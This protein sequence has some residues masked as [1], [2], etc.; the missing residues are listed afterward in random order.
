M[1]N[2][3]VDRVGTEFGEQ[4]ISSRIT[5]VGETRP[6]I[7]ISRRQEAQIFKILRMYN[8]SKSIGAR[9]QLLDGISNTTYSLLQRYNTFT[10]FAASENFAASVLGRAAWIVGGRALGRL[11]SRLVPQ[12]GGP[13]GRF[14][15]V[16]AGHFSRNI[17]SNAMKYFVSVEM[18]I[19]NIPQ[20]QKDITRDLMRANQLGPT[21]Q[22]LTH[23]QAIKTAPDY[24]VGGFGTTGDMGSRIDNIKVF[25]LDRNSQYVQKLVDAGFTGHEINALVNMSQ[26]E[27]SMLGETDID[28]VINAFGKNRTSMLKAAN[29]PYNLRNNL[30]VDYARLYEFGQRE[31]PNGIAEAIK[32]TTGGD[33]VIDEQ[34]L[35]S[36]GFNTGGLYTTHDLQADPA[37][38]ADL[39][40]N[41]FSG[42]QRGKN[43]AKLYKRDDKNNKIESDLQRLG[44]RTKV[45]NGKIVLAPRDQ[46]MND[47]DEFV[48]E[49]D[50][51]VQSVLKDGLDIDFLNHRQVS[52]Q[53]TH[54]LANYNKF[55]NAIPSKRL[56]QSDIESLPPLIG[57]KANQ[58]TAFLGFAVS[59]GANIRDA[60]QIEYGGPATDS[61]GKLKRRSDRFIYPRS[62]FMAKSAEYAANAL[63]IK[64]KIGYSQAKGGVMKHM[65]TNKEKQDVKE[66][67]QNSNKANTEYKLILDRRMRDILQEYAIRAREVKFN[68]ST[69]KYENMRKLSMEEGNINSWSEKFM[70]SSVAPRSTSVVRRIPGEGMKLVDLNPNDPKSFGGM[71]PQAFENGLDKIA[72]YFTQKM[73]NLTGQMPLSDNEFYRQLGRAGR[74]QGG[75]ILMG[76]DHL[77]M[78]GLKRNNFNNRPFFDASG[79][80]NQLFYGGIYNEDDYEGAL[81]LELRNMATPIYIEMYKTLEKKAQMKEASIFVE[82]IAPLKVQ[83]KYLA[84]VQVGK[85]GD[86]IGL[87]KKVK[88]QL[89]EETKIQIERA[90]AE[91]KL[92]SDEWYEVEVKKLEQ[93]FNNPT[94]LGAFTEYFGVESD[95]IN[96]IKQKMDKRIKQII[97]SSSRQNMPTYRQ[98]TV[99][100]LVNRVARGM[101]ALNDEIRGKKPKEEIDYG[102]FLRHLEVLKELL[103]ELKDL[104]L[105]DVS[106]MYR[107]LGYDTYRLQN[108]FIQKLVSEAGLTLGNLRS[109]DVQTILGEKRE[110]VIK[111]D[112]DQFRNVIA[113]FFKNA[114]REAVQGLNPA[115]SKKGRTNKFGDPTASKGG[116]NSTRRNPLIINFGS[117]QNNVA[118]EHQFELNA[119]ESKTIINDYKIIKAAVRAGGLER[120]SNRPKEGPKKK[121]KGI[122]NQRGV[123]YYVDAGKSI[124]GG[125]P[126]LRE[127]NFQRVIGR[128]I[129]N[130]NH[131]DSNRNLLHFLLALE[132]D[133]SVS[134]Y[135]RASLNPTHPLNKQ[136]SSV[137]GTKK[138]PSLNAGLRPLDN[139]KLQYYIQLT[140]VIHNGIP[141]RTLI[142]NYIL[143]S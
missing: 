51:I 143:N 124:Y 65:R 108:D 137:R 44:V 47:M 92:Q 111:R 98:Q 19:K 16:Q 49:Y 86:V 53:V 42:R 7:L 67:N 39:P 66:A 43:A 114:Q 21:W 9:N 80:R 99:A 15:R 110:D 141:L 5:Y 17:L 18:N 37:L 27:T 77:K 38:L 116:A 136:K 14:F 142:K 20:I 25:K 26:Q 22:K 8:W 121:K 6:D 117:S 41:S 119:R 59:F 120:V 104:G 54:D 23:A 97:S 93:K 138:N 31:L 36:N 112:I 76:D 79:L 69:G 32:F 83:N 132:D 100:V 115:A 13:F 75:S 91:A 64:G 78:H 33:M 70:D 90:R 102:K 128:F 24:R 46:A 72:K 57:G 58:G 84:N 29:D 52:Q 103:A 61:D 11:Q 134:A 1:P 3:T 127:V 96:A 88:S 85:K 109:L 45:V 73:V 50:A 55:D 34:W 106:E 62:L 35:E 129:D 118:P 101:E 139:A 71:Y 68:P 56:I 81:L 82:L 89:D 94:G 125:G 40:R 95:A 105:K 28:R 130:V 4:I 113:D 30:M 140:N 133:P 123:R 131:S 135:I 60:Q 87:T 63:G 2:L 10:S 126:E 48:E 122:S 12:G 74:P 107:Y